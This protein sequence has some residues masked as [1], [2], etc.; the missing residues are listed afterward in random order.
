[1]VNLLNKNTVGEIDKL[2]ENETLAVLNYISELLSARLPNPKTIPKMTIIV[3]AGYYENKAPVSIEWER[4]RRQLQTGS[5]R[6][7]QK[8]RKS[9][10]ILF[11][12][13][14]CLREFFAQ[15]LEILP[16]QVS[17]EHRQTHGFVKSAI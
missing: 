4:V 9:K 13:F 2:N 8:A 3:F 7:S 10:L 15:N 5:V 16:E 14:V 17:A 11:A 1:M 12:L 6:K